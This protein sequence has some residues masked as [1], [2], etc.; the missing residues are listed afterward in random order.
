MEKQF[1]IA[2]A[3]NNLTSMI[4][5]VEAGI[6]LKITRHGKPVAVLLSIREYDLLKIKKGDFWA[7]LVQ[8]RKEMEKE[9][10]EITDSDFMD[11]RDSFFGRE[12]KI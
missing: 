10:V 1:S 11:L 2:E 6:F 8:F 3:K 5:D 9:N 4:R 7:K 12:V